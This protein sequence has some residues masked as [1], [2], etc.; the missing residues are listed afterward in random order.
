VNIGRAVRICRAARGWTQ[1][2]L[3]NKAAIGR[4][5]MCLVEKGKRDL[6][7]DALGRVCEAL[8]IPQHVF[9]MIAATAEE[10]DALAPGAC[11]SALRWLQEAAE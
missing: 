11:V 7:L 4:S 10:I 3:G 8:D 6:S 1:T 9:M 2:D 5:M